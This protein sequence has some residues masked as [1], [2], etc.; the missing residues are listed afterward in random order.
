VGGV[1]DADSVP[2]RNSATVG[3]GIAV[4]DRSR[5]FF[6]K[7]DRKVLMRAVLL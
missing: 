1:S 5:R 4:R 3:T 6:G 7:V 2:P